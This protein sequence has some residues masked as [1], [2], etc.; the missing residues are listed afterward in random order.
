[1]KSAKRLDF[2]DEE[3]NDTDDSPIRLPPPDARDQSV[4]I[5]ETDIENCSVEKAAPI[6]I[7]MSPSATMPHL[8]EEG[9]IAEHVEFSEASRSIV[10][11][12]SRTI[13]HLEVEQRSADDERHTAEQVDCPETSR[14]IEMSPTL[15][16]PI[17]EEQRITEELVC[18]E[19]S[20]SIEISKTLPPF[21][22]ENLIAEELECP[23]A[24]PI[25]DHESPILI[26]PLEEE[27]RF[28]EQVV[29][30]EASRSIEETMSIESAFLTSECSPLMRE[31]PLKTST[32]K[33][34]SAYEDQVDDEKASPDEKDGESDEKEDESDKKEAEK[35]I[36]RIDPSKLNLFESR[37]APITRSRGKKLNKK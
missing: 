36:Y 13:P 28:A 33:N 12:P 8:E 17:E 27:K 20:Q 24:A 1:M 16:P 19:A 30:P 29:C 5:S 2:I 4:H 23:E 25:D 14:S 21:E 26:P 9:R 32:P 22:E 35:V 15:S 3:K 6:D 7:V 11:S 10:M 34:L 31:P 37:F 18:P